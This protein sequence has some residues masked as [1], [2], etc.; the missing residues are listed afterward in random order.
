MSLVEN[1]LE[2]FLKKFLKDVNHT[3]VDHKII[4]IFMRMLLKSS[5]SYYVVVEDFY[6]SSSHQ[7]RAFWRSFGKK[8]QE[9]LKSIN[10]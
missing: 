8:F 4:S 6:S 9:K 5:D 10:S 2:K 1:I 7:L 3:M